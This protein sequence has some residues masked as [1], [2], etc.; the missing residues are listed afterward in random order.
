MKAKKPSREFH[1]PPPA[2]CQVQS[3]A[4]APDRE[5]TIREYIPLVKY[6][7]G[8]LKMRIPPHI[9]MDDLVSSGIVGLLDALERFD[10]SRGIKFKTYAEFRIRGAM[11]DYLREMDWF[12][13]SLR[14]RA[15]N[16]QHVYSQLE[17]LLRRPPS[18]E[19][20]AD[21]MD[22]PLETL[23]K[24]L[25]MLSGLSVF[26]LD[27]QSDDEVDAGIARALAEAA[28][29]EAKEA[30]LLRDLKEVLGKAIDL[31]PEKERNLIA[32]YYYEELTMKEIGAILTLGEPRICQLHNQ[33]V[34]RLRGKLRQ[35]LQR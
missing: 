17:V 30:E 19:E 31:L 15:V 18:E 33:A 8:M 21:H 29:D 35:Q 4:K 10:P 24:E 12:P 13:R 28:I 14:Q 7:A 32:L 5:A 3:A 1:Q 23:Q 11:L 20:V 2:A 34:L 22:I 27:A 26:S 9:E 25:T 16:L 6:H